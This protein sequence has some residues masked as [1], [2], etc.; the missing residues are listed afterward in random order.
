MKKTRI[1]IALIVT[2][3]TALSILGG[4]TKSTN[5]TSGQAPAAATGGAKNPDIFVIASDSEPTLLDPHIAYDPMSSD[6]IMQ[7]YESLVIFKDDT[8]EVIPFLA[9]SW[10]VS[11]EGRVWTFH[12]RDDVKFSDGTQFNA[13]A[14]KVNFDRLLSINQGPAWMYDMI[15]KTEVVDNFTVRFNLEYPYASFLYAIASG[16]GA[17]FISP[18]AI[19]DNE[20]NGDQA[21]G[22]LR[23]HMVG[24]GPYVLDSW[25]IGQGWSMSKNPN[26]WRGWTGN[27][28][29]RIELKVVKES[30]SRMLML[31]NGDADFAENI[32]RDTLGQ[33]SGNPDVKIIQKP[34]INVLNICLNNQ[35]GALKDKRV[36][37]AMSYAFSYDDAVFGIYTGR[38]SYQTGPMASGVW[39][40]NPNVVR[41]KTDLDKAKKLLAEAGY[42]NGGGLKFTC[43]VE[44]GA[45]DYAK[46]V[47]LF[48]A[49]MAKIGITI[50]IQV[51]SWATMEDMLASAETAADMFI[52]G[53]Y[54]DFPDP[55]NALYQQFHSSGIGNIN[56]SF[57][58][59][60]EADKLL[61]SARRTVEDDKRL[62]DY[63]KVQMIIN[64]DAPCVFILVRDMIVTY[65]SWVQNYIYNPFVRRQYYSICK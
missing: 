21:M 64:E 8:S 61:D 26:Y 6:A 27:H 60:P 58:I 3:V 62:E 55:D 52:T 9:K 50:N 4:C 17:L 38:A 40:F 15:T 45:D 2:L 11:S 33:L 22:W 18:K 1:L 57:Y 13:E 29:S 56:Q 54:P 5:Q 7:S 16:D 46:V 37:Q 28:A 14:V 44:T 12:L 10:D 39:A 48:Q 49:D 43:Q 42:A 59:N 25:V 65:R 47:E 63:H 31:E 34:S 30:A 35:R 41:Y 20:V 19:K 23:D 51:L 53:V 24:T 32:T 36:R